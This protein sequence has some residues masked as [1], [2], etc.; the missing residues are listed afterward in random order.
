MVSGVGSL[1]NVLIIIVILVDPLKILRKGSWIS[2]ITIIN[3]AAADL[4]VCVNEFFYEIQ[5]Y[6]GTKEFRTIY[7]Y[8]AIFLLRLA[9]SASFMLLAFFSLQVYTVT[10]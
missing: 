10:K 5:T 4:A 7:S 8:L 1:S 3:L 9:I 2:W 6:V